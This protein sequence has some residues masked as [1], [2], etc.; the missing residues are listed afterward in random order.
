MKVFFL[1][2]FFSLIISQKSLLMEMSER[3]MMMRVGTDVFFGKNIL[4]L[5]WHMGMSVVINWEKR[6]YG[7]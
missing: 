1:S 7:K 6:C 5:V 3:V 2:M 4:P